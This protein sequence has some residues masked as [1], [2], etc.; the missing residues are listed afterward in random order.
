MIGK[1]ENSA[2]IPAKA[3]NKMIQSPNVTQ[4]KLYQMLEILEN[5]L[6]YSGLLQ[7]QYVLLGFIK[8]LDLRNYPNL[9]QIY[10]KL[11]NLAICRGCET[12]QQILINTCGHSYCWNCAQ[13]FFE[14]TLL[15]PCGEELSD[16]L[17]VKLARA[18]KKKL[19]CKRCQNE[20]ELVDLE[21]NF[22]GH[23][24]VDCVKFTLESFETECFYCLKNLLTMTDLFN[25]QVQCDCCLEMRF[26]IGDSVS[27]ICTCNSQCRFCISCIEY[28]L[29]TKE[30]KLCSSRFSS[31]KLLEIYKKICEVCEKCHK[32]YSKTNILF[33]TC[34]QTKICRGCF[35]GPNKCCD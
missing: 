26:L 20:V 21:N 18:M 11:Y 3:S 28:M 27:P 16:I 5:C 4:E 19:P 6:D 17:Q 1:E 8:D 31:E 14:N 33:R 7:S 13:K 12:T 24:C 10:E 15:C 23:M 34:C 2:I 35:E 30:C 25:L 32:V 29:A 22:C 9:N